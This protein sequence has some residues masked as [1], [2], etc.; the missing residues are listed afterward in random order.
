MKSKYLSLI[1]AVVC[2]LPMASAHAQDGQ[3]DEP[4]YIVQPGD[5]LWAIAQQFGV[6]I[7][8]LAA[9][10]Q[11]SKQS[12]LSIGARLIIPGLE[13]ISGIL[14]TDSVNYGESLES[15]SRR[16]GVSPT[17]LSILNR[18]TSPD[19]VYAGSSLIIPF[20][21]DD[22]VTPVGGRATLKVGQS[23]LELAIA[24]GIS[25][26]TLITANHLENS[27]SVIP[28]ETLYYPDSEKRGPGALPENVVSVDVG[29][30]PLVQG[31]TMVVKIE[32][33]PGATLTGSFN[34]LPLN[35]FQVNNGKYVALQGIHAMLDPGYYDLA[36][37]GNLT[38]DMPIV[39]SQKVYIRDGAYP[40][41]PPLVVNSETIDNET[42]AFENQA[43]FDAVAPLTA[44]KSWDG[45]FLSPVPSI[46]SECFPSL[47]G[48]RRSYND[49][50][51]YF[52]H[53][54]LDFC[55]HVGVE[56]YAPAAGKIVFAESTV[57]RGNATI[58]DHGWGVFSAYAHQDQMFVAVG[59]QVKAGQLIGYVG[60]T[61]RVTGP[62]L[63]W[64]ILV[65]GVQVNPQ[66]WMQ[67][68]Y[69]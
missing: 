32:A 45:V 6:S 66:Q 18:Y 54:G 27:W 51:Y 49:G 22:D 26:W 61:G 17:N 28:G 2:L 5:S 20:I 1:F 57:V 34:G 24:H 39:F 12:Q 3:S 35:F 69:P 4:V 7:D 67:M 62:H 48:N 60:A 36:I 64:E 21:G 11:M 42:N 65:G 30:S 56:I 19:E 44:E 59:D 41:D 55:G 43:W 52:F 10:N 40:Y 31:Q 25:P 38:E 50:G 46:F 29:P 15:L 63:H 9:K 16:Y 13:G 53:T 58:I 8:A 47:F 68:V 33:V 23:L 14:V 37:F